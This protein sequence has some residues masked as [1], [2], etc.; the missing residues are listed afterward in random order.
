[1]KLAARPALV[2]LAVLAA[3]LPAPA[4]ERTNDPYPALL[5]VSPRLAPIAGTK[6]EKEP[7]LSGADITAVLPLWPGVSLAGT[8]RVRADRDFSRPGHRPQLRAVLNRDYTLSERTVARLTAGREF[9]G[10]W[11]VGATLHRKLRYD[12][13]VG[14]GVKRTEDDTTVSASVSIPLAWGRTHR[15]W[16]AHRAP[17]W[18][19]LPGQ[20]VGNVGALTQFTWERDLSPNVERGR[21]NQLFSEGQYF[22]LPTYD[23]PRLGRDVQGT[24]Y[25]PVRLP[26]PLSERWEFASKGA[27][28]GGIALVDDT[29]YAPSEDHN[30][31]ALNLVTGEERWRVAAKS[32]LR[33]APAVAAGRV[34]FGSDEGL[35][36]CVD[37]STPNGKQSGHPGRVRWSHKTAGPI[38]GCPI[39]TDNEKCIF[40]SSD[41]SVYCFGMWTGCRLWMFPTG[42]R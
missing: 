32:P 23:W 5:F 29:V 25:A 12:L 3:T 38:T 22:F 16:L 39:L 15:N 30:L 1:M 4:Q 11:M 7:I 42:G 18:G 8:V 40:G 21:P 35:M 13:G 17:G 27:L 26:L 37:A 33:G 36:Y 28:S 19:R 31:Y 2:G 34:Y 24:G 9:G 41:G 6:A 14:L 20:S 10:P